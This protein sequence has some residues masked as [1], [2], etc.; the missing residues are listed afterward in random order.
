MFKEKKIPTIL[1]LVI[2]IG[3][4]FVGVFL[5]NKNTNFISKASGDCSPINPQITNITNNSVSVS[6]LTESSCLSSLVINN[7][8]IENT[9]T[10]G[11]NKKS[12]IRK[13]ITHY[14]IY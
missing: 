7:Q 9:A 2:L 12:K 5:T 11:D 8:T 14:T 4:V 10:L 1:G 13:F 6:F 3:G